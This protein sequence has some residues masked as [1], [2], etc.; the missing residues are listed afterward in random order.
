LHDAIIVGGG[1]AGSHV[2]LKLS[3]KGHRVMVLE[4]KRRVGD[5][6]CCTGIIGQECV[7][8]FAIEGKVILRQVSGARLFSPSGNQLSLWREEPQACI[9]DRAA[10]DISLAER[11]QEAGAIYTFN[12]LVKDIDV[13][14]D[15]VSVGVSCQGK[16]IGF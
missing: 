9:L 10:F 13:T 14:R 8:A 4:R 12:S 2:A 1:P 7:D 16:E 11:A 6:V 15:R 5:S 3:E